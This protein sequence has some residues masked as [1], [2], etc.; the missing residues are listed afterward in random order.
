YNVAH[1]LGVTPS[2]VSRWASNSHT[3]HKSHTIRIDLLLNLVTKAAGGDRSALYTLSELAYEN[4]NSWLKLGYEGYL[5]ASQHEWALRFPGKPGQ[6]Q[7][8]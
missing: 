6:S 8:Q 7:N 1:L 5:I 4:S 2:T 3:P